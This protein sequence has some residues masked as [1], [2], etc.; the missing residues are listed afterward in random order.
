MTSRVFA[1]GLMSALLALMPVTGFAHHG[2]DFNDNSYDDLYNNVGIYNDPY[3][4]QY[5]STHY[6]N[7]Y[8]SNDY[9]ED[10]RYNT[11]SRSYNPQYTMPGFR[12][13][14]WGRD[15][16]CMNYSYR[17]APSYYGGYPYG[18]DRYSAYEENGTYGNRCNHPRCY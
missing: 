6:G 14:N 18:Y 9:Y 7:N 10:D 16:T 3:S 4:T 11:N 2:V 12:C 15:G 5:G 17:Q 1:T 8:R 13:Y